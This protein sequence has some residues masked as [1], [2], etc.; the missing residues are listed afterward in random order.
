[1]LEGWMS[2]EGFPSAG[3]TQVIAYVMYHK[4]I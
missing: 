4:W 2:A 3:K 1:M